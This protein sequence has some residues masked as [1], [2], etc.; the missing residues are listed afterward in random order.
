[1]QQQTLPLGRGDLGRESALHAAYLRCA[2]VR[3]RRSFQEMLADPLLRRA[4]ELTAR[5]MQKEF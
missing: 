3:R 5:N 4:L 1:M 2:A